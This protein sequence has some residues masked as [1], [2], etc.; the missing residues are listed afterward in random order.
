VGAVCNRK[1]SWNLNS[2][3]QGIW[4]LHLH[5]PAK[6]LP[7][8]SLQVASANAESRRSAHG[9][10]HATRLRAFGREALD[11]HCE[12][13]S[14]GPI[15]RPR[16]DRRRSA[17]WQCPR[18]VASFTCSPPASSRSL[19]HCAQIY[20]H[21]TRSLCVFWRVGLPPVLCEYLV[22]DLTLDKRAQHRLEP[23]AFTPWHTVQTG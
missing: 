6:Q 10:S 7:A 11:K 16:A 1:N 17:N 8:R 12:P 5:G 18:Y 9:E 23:L 13:S 2:R 21:D 19:W 14:T 15:T 3:G 4:D 20:C 22:A